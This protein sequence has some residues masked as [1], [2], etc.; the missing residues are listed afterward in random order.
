MAIFLS[1]EAFRPDASGTTA[2]RRHFVHLADN[3]TAQFAYA[4]VGR[5]C[6]DHDRNVDRLILG[7]HA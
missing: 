5:H 3:R 7:E 6:G 4:R 1:G 2:R